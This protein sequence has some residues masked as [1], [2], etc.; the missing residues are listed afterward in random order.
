[1]PEEFRVEPDPQPPKW[2]GG[3]ADEL[4]AWLWDVMECYGS[5][6]YPHPICGASEVHALSL[7]SIKSKVESLW[8]DDWPAAHTP[9]RGSGSWLGLTCQQCLVNG[10]QHM[11]LV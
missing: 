4:L 9:E 10:Y 2:F 8:Q 6:A 7:D 5:A 11:L 1:M 3:L